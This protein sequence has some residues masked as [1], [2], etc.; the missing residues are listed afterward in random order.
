MNLSL[1]I[2]G[3]KGPAGLQWTLSYPSDVTS[4][5]IAAGP[6]LTGA[7]KS[8][9]CSTGAG[10]LTCV[11]SGMNANQIAAGT[12]A[13]VTATIASGTSN[14]SD[15]IPMT[16]V[17]G[18]CTDA[19]LFSMAGTGGTVTI[20][21]P[22]PVITSVGTAGGSTG[23][24]F[25]YQIVATNSPTSFGAT[26]LPA[27][28]AVSATSGL[29]SGTPTAAGTSTVTLSATNASG[30]GSAALAL[31]IQPPPPVITGPTA[32]TAAV[33]T[34]FSYQIAASNSPTSF[35]ATGLPAGLA[36]NTANGLISGTPTTA[37]TSTVTLSATN[38]GGTGNATLALTIQPPSPVIN[39]P[40]TA[41]AAVGT[42]FSYQIA[43]SNSPTSFTATGL[44]AGLAISTTTGLIS[45]TPTAAGT[46]TVTLSATNSGGTGNATLALTIQPP[47]PVINSP[48]TATAAVGTAFS[49]QIAASNSPTSFAATGLPA[50][51]AVNTANGLISGTPTTA[52]TSTVTLSATN[53]GGTGNATLT[54]TI[55]P[56]VTGHHQPHDRHRGLSALPSLIRLRPATLPP[57]ITATGLPAGLAI[58]TTTGLISGTPTAAGTSTVTLSATNAGGTGNATLTLTI[59][60]PSPVITSAATASGLSGLP[61]LIRLQPPTL[62]PVMGRRDCRQGCRLP[63]G[64]D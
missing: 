54:L 15:S 10:S 2:G 40:A 39:S 47:S 8:L 50:G 56:P 61:S 3:T 19:T 46:S 20:L 26:G 5:T 9:S 49:Y 36:V 44:P 24:A 29:I 31:T 13:V 21:N 25:S 17:M 55:Q 11:A 43:A 60:A 30:S 53:S 7:S 34:A 1:T 42:A 48:A 51:L 41:T 58:S 45:G 59:A 38:S 32:A 16:N 63:A 23:S 22:V 4:L 6:A 64:P 35:A 12:V 27:G 14:S 33:G 57:A 52:G 28:L 18:V 37:G 62:R